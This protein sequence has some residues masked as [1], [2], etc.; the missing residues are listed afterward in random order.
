M[1][2]KA[3]A[4]YSKASEE[5]APP[6]Y[7]NVAIKWI[8]ELDLRG[9]LK[10]I[11]Q[12]SDGS[13]SK[14]DRGRRFPA[15]HI[16]KT[17]A[18]R[19]K[20]LADN[21]EY[22]LGIGRKSSKRAKVRRRH[23]DFIDEVR[24][25]ATEVNE[26]TVNAVLR[27]LKTWEVNKA[28]LPRDF[29][30]AEI[31]TFRVAGTF[32]MLQESVQRY[33]ARTAAPNDGPTMMCLVCGEDRPAVSRLAFKIK[34]PGGQRSGTALIS[35]NAKAFESYGLQ[36]SL[37]APVCHTCSEAF[38][39]AA[40]ILIKAEASHIAVGSITYVF[41]ARNELNFNPAQL[42]REP[43]PQQVR[44]LLE[45]PLTG[46]DRTKADLEP[47][48]VAA[49]SA[50][51]S[52][53]VVRDWLQIT[54]AEAKR[55]LARYFMLQRIG[56]EWKPLK[57][58]ALAAATARKSATVRK[59]TATV[60]RKMD[61]S[62]PQTLRQL[63]RFALYGD[64]LPESLLHRVVMRNRAEQQVTQARAAL[65]KM[66]LLSQD[67]DVAKGENP[68]VELD[69]EQCNPAYLCGRLLAVLEQ[70]QDRAI[71]GLK[72]GIVERFYG[73]ASSTPAAVF[74]T[75]IRKAMAHLG[76]IQAMNPGA[77]GALQQRLEDIMAGITPAFPNTLTMREQGLF[78]L[79]Y[80]HQRAHDRTQARE[81]KQAKEAA[82]AAAA[83]VA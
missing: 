6:M 38:A 63:M 67:F 64:R 8:V 70:I 82:Q 58:F 39:K 73:A 9:K 30:P 22:S 76:K 5:L 14:N 35:A 19:A 42:L 10:G 74:P 68:M 80:Y 59:K 21:G 72:N 79:G 13:G 1:L 34:L 49:L 48:Y 54:T 41:W 31:V 16:M 77:H 12:T 69:S 7:E 36:N 25:C 51:N 26:P 37:V 81:R 17:S 46:A 52:R 33:W 44:H 55:N 56:S 15:P 29:N 53:L 4:E 57:L 50:N 43:D 47:F 61:G 78:S 23:E 11:V 71:P 24:K 28:F 75:L 20:L 83:N 32:P 66:V 27:F 2:L 45:S 40:N 3:L 60:R 65:A 62:S 18:V